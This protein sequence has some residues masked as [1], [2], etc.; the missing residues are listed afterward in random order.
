MYVCVHKSMTAGCCTSLA[1]KMKDGK[2]VNMCCLQLHWHPGESCMVLYMLIIV[3]KCSVQNVFFVLEQRVAGIPEIT[4]W[5]DDHLMRLALWPY[6]ICVQY[7]FVCNCFPTSKIRL[8]QQY[9]S[10]SFDC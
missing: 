9:I 10:K 6:T 4:N 1:T 2:G 8:L 3:R 5:I 7:M